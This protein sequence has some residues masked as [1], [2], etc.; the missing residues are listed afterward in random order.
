VEHDPVDAGGGDGEPANDESRCVIPSR[1][2][3][4]SVNEA[5]ARWARTRAVR[6]SEAIAASSAWRIAEAA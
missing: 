3:S 5:W 2:A 1:P 6:A 4:A